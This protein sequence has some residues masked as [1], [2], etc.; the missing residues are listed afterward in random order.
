MWDEAR[1]VGRS[2]GPV[3]PTPP[4]F[5]PEGES[6]VAGMWRT[7]V[8]QGLTWVVFGVLVLVWPDLSL[9]TLVALIAACALVHA[10]ISGAA[11][12]AVPNQHRGRVWLAL[13]ALASVVVAV[14]VLGWPDPGATSIL[15]VVAAWAIVIGILQMNGAHV[16]PLGGER[17]TLLAWTGAVPVTFGVVMLIEARD[18][19]LADTALIAAFALVTGVM[20]CAFGIDLRR[21]SRGRSS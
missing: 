16:L 4:G 9:E 7:I 1:E 11:A 18:G 10:A 14:V 5:L 19:A 6:V 13:D 2:V 17:A 8:A 15:T 21:F 20:Q 12:F 3:D